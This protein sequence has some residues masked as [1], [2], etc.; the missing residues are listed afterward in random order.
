MMQTS[1]Y[2]SIPRCIPWSCN[3]PDH[4]EASTVA[5]MRKAR[6][7]VAARVPLQNA[8]VLRPIERCTP[9]F[10]LAHTHPRF[11]RM[12]FGHPPMFTYCPRA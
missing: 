3:A 8:A 5:H 4:F 9:R 1:M 10:E 7:V 12:Q 2:T 11:L 6:I